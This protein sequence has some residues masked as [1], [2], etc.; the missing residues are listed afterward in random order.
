[1]DKKQLEGEPSAT[2]EDSKAGED[3]SFPNYIAI[4]AEFFTPENIKTFEEELKKAAPDLDIIPKRRSKEERLK[5]YRL[6]AEDLDVNPA[7]YA[8]EDPREIEKMVRVVLYKILEEGQ[9][10]KDVMGITENFLE[11]FYAMACSY[12]N[13]GKYEKALTA[14]TILQA[15]EVGSFRSRFGIASSLH[16][17]ERYDEAPEYYFAAGLADPNNPLPFLHVCDCYLKKDDIPSAALAL[18]Y[19]LGCCGDNPKWEAVKNQAKI[20]LG[21][22]L[23][24]E[25]A[26]SES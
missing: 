4:L 24:F 14:F 3:N 26:R 15:I 11:G 13:N 12:Y 19:C 7:E 21:S 10:T 22:L 17:L 20:I 2:A 16:Q 6:T 5:V 23:A 8:G 25:E 18:Q 1:M 9:D